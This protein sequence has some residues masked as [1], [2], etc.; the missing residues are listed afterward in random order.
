MSQTLLFT[1]EFKLTNTYAHDSCESVEILQLATLGNKHKYKTV[2][3]SSDLS[4][5]D[6]SA[7]QSPSLVTLVHKRA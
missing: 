5:I 7:H 2:I 6:A 3:L 1:G 4:V